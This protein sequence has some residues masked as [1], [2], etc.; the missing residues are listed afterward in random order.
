[1]AK[2]SSDLESQFPL[3]SLLIAILSLLTKMPI[4]LG[5]LFLL[6]PIMNLAGI[7]VGVMGITVAAN[8]REMKWR[9][10]S[11]VGIGVNLLLMS[12]LFIPLR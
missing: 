1:M 2:S 5:S 9:I 11:Y 4:G 3:I 8:S 12:T 6:G 10:L 7:V